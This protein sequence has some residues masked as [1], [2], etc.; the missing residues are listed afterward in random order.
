MLEGTTMLIESQAFPSFLF[1]GLAMKHSMLIEAKE[2]YQKRS[3]RNRYYLKSMS[4]E[5]VCLS[6]P[7]QQGKNQAQPIQEVKISYQQNWER[8]HLKSLQTIYGKTP[9]FKEYMDELSELYIQQF[10]FLFEFNQQCTQWLIDQ[11]KISCH[12]RETELYHKGIQ[13]NIIDLR[14]KSWEQILQLGDFKIPSSYAK[15][16]QSVYPS[17]SSLD[18]LFHLGPEAIMVLKEI[19]N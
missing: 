9:F 14:N 15:R 5:R 13:E 16:S 10:T 19:C 7:L 17:L 18:L 8:Q 12:L 11:F 1:F 4:N 2:N 3:C 6:I